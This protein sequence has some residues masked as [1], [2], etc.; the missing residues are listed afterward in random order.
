[1]FKTKKY[2][3]VATQFIGGI[4]FGSLALT[5]QTHNFFGYSLAF[6]AVIAFN[7]ATHD[8]ATDGVYINVLN[9]KEQA[10]FI[11]WQGAFYNVAKVLSQGAFVFIAGQL[12]QSIGLVPAWTIVMA[13]FGCNNGCA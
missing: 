6:F 9:A 4:S 11:G 1:M 7:G 2:F 10:E 13:I 3:V 5:L 12:E 8:I